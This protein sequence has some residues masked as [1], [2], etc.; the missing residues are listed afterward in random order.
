MNEAI[1]IERVPLNRLGKI[2]DLLSL[3][4]AIRDITEP[5]TT[6]G[7]LRQ[8]LS[9]LSS[10]ADL[11]GI[12]PVWSERLA[13]VL[14]DEGVFNI[15]LAIIQYV[16]GAAGKEAADHSIRVRVAD[17]GQEVIV[18]EQSFAAWLPLVIQLLSLLRQIRGGQ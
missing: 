17:A 10:L 11:V 18:D 1:S 16:S 15:V 4:G 13:S 8:A 14:R 6:A 5:L 9:L 7:G 3:L 12:D 2:R